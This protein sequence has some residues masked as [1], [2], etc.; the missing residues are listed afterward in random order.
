VESKDVRGGFLQTDHGQTTSSHT[1]VVSVFKS[2]WLPWVSKG[3]LG[4]PDHIP[5]IIYA[6]QLLCLLFSLRFFHTGQ[7]FSKR[8]FMTSMPLGSLSKK[9]HTHILKFSKL[10]SEPMVNATCLKSFPSYLQELQPR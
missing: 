1:L 7:L 8:Q 3:L 5:P 6:S 2:F 10:N 4:H 9:L